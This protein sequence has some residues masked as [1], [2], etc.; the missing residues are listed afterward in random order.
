MQATAGN[1]SHFNLKLKGEPGT[2]ASVL[3]SFATYTD[4]AGNYGSQDLAI[5]IP[6]PKSQ[7]SV[8]SGAESSVI[9]GTMA[10]T[11]AVSITS[12]GAQLFSSIANVTSTTCVVSS[13]SSAGG[14]GNFVRAIG[15]TQFLA[16]C[17][18]LAVPNLPNSFV[19]MSN[20]YK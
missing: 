20:G 14:G 4:L 17:T 7:V 16:M 2:N 12:A 19:E 13:G 11:T 1:G 9:L 8:L 5:L 15:H 6:V 10:A 3:L 18:S